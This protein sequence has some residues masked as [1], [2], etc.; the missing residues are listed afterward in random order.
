MSRKEESRL[1]YLSYKEH[2]I[3]VQCGSQKAAPHRVRCEECLAKNAESAAIVREGKQRDSRAE[4]SKAL[5][6]RRKEQGLCVWCGKPQ[7]KNSSCFCLDC[8]LKNQRK[9]ERKKVDIDRSE[10][11]I[12]G[13]CYRCGKH[14]IEP[15]KKLCASCIEQSIRNLPDDNKALKIIWKPQNNLLFQRKMSNG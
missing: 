13:I 9:N 5:R 3:C 11:P 10:R 6:K 8:R 7:C 14:P 12:Y 4:Y 2:G 1:N 15:E